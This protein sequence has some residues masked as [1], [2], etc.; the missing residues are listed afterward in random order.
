MIIRNMPL[1]GA[2]VLGTLV[3]GGP[4]GIQVMA[5]FQPFQAGAIATRVMLLP[6]ALGTRE[7]PL[8]RGFTYAG[9][10]GDFGPLLTNIFGNEPF[11]EAPPTE[12]AKTTETAKKTNTRN[13]SGKKGG[14]IKILRTK[15]TGY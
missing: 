3:H 9:V 8:H 2:L 12:T 7:L 5:S 11:L 13:R 6:R 1:G 15:T 4:N 14:F 10:L